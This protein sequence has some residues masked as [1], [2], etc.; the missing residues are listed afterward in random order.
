MTQL[1]KFSLYVTL[2][3]LITSAVG[4][5]QADPQSGSTVSA[6]AATPGA[7]ATPSDPQFQEHYP[8]YI[9]RESDVFDI[10]FDLSPEFN[11]AGV[12]V[13]PDGFVTLR[14][15]GDVRV[16]GQSV[17]QLVATLRQAYSK[18]LHDPIISIV[19][20]DFQKPYFIADGQL[21]KPGKYELRG[22]VTLTEAIAM[23]G[24]FLESAKH[25]QVLL[26]RRVNDQWSSARIINVK[27]M[28]KEGNLKED[29]YL[30]AG[31]ML[32]VPKNFMSKIRPFVPN[33]GVSVA[34]F[35]RQY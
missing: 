17:T 20:K 21:G 10:N 31:D 16:V 15:V 28:E 35:N 11:Q 34:A 18:V 32:F 12:V 19:L 33:S 5:A 14:G 23:A 9:L 3:L 30:R 29:P 13:Q 25:S 4:T 7:T 6:P 24:G 27:E 8:R 26:F 1:L 2:A 22:D